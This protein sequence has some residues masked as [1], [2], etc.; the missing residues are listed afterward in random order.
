MH[1]RRHT[2]TSTHVQSAHKRNGDNQ[3]QEPGWEGCKK[4]FVWD[5][6]LAY[7]PK[8]RIEKKWYLLILKKKFE[9]IELPAKLIDY[10]LP[11]NKSNI[12][13]SWTQIRD[14]KFSL[15]GAKRHKNKPTGMFFESSSW[16]EW[17]GK[18]S[19]SWQLILACIPAYTQISKHH[20]YIHWC[21]FCGWA[22]PQTGGAVQSSIVNG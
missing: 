4:T 14:F 9:H 3:A 1:I 5:K 15:T 21:I 13:Q 6:C 8:R 11:S 18:T 17:S 16:C 19:I 22:H 7:T 20:L 12:N 2:R 10:F